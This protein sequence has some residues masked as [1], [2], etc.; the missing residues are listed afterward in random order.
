M[1]LFLATLLFVFFFNSVSTQN[2]PIDFEENGYGADWTWTTFENDSNPELEI[3]TNPDMS[4]INT[5][6]T[7]AQFTALQ[8]GQPFAGVE[9]MHGA[10]IGTFTI[11]QSN[12]IIRIMV[13]K[14]VISDVGIK[15]VR[16]DGWSLGE[17]KIA[18]T[19]TNEWEQLEFNF[20]EHIGNEYDQIV[21][22]PD[23]TDRNEDNIIYIDNIY[24]EAATTSN[25][26]H[27]ES[28]VKIY[29]NPTDNFISIQSKQVING[30]EIYSSSG[31]LVAS[32]QY[33]NSNDIPVSSLPSGIY[34]LKAFTDNEILTAKFT[35]K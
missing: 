1:K 34:H 7:V 6:S 25:A 10:G 12:S 16:E 33:F 20:S 30:Y 35:K 19:V 14:S 21:V 26:E 13:W 32:N 2:I 31:T 11:D 4:G 5:S 3:I 22:F 24:G 8:Q 15:L 23:F 27:E 9:S 29:P 18:N 17:M 28:I